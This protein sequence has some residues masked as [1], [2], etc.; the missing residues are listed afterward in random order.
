MRAQIASL[1]A[2]LFVYSHSYAN[3]ADLART[4]VYKA[5]VAIPGYSWTGWYVG[6]NAGYGFGGNNSASVT[7]QDSAGAAAIAAGF[8]PDSVQLE[9]SGFV[10]GGQIGYTWQFNSIVYGFE[11][12]IQYAN[13]KD[14]VNRATPNAAGVLRDNI[15]EQKL[16]FFGTVRGRLGLAWDRTLFYATGGL[17]YGGTN[18]SGNFYNPAG[19]AFSGSV[20]R[21]EVG[22][23]V[24]GGVEHA[25]SLNWTARIEYLYYDLADTTA[26]V[27]LLPGVAS[28]TAGYNVTFENSGHIIRAGVNFR[29]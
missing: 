22:Y 12:D 2:A 17:A 7:G 16:E 11:A 5:P 1:A 25:F 21:T 13:I 3:S 4:P 18:N 28:T 20:K 6:L 24:G 23:S 15:F 26:A 10:G 19:L 14:D 8:R 29:Y 27:S 9:P